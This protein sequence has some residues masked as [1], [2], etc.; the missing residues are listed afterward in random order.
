M[1]EVFP[2]YMGKGI[3]SILQIAATNYALANNRYPYGQVAET[4]QASIALQ[5]KLDFKFS[6]SKIYWLMR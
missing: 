4:N 3:G 2:E 1:L 6:N 5:K